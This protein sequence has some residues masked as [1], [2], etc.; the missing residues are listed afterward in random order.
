MATKLTDQIKAIVNRGAQLSEKTIEEQMKWRSTTSIA[1][2]LKITKEEALVFSY[3]YFLTLTKKSFDSQNIRELL[4]NDPFELPRIIT[5]LNDLY[6]S[7]LL[8]RSSDFLSEGYQVPKNI[9]LEI[10][11]NEAPAK[12]NSSKKDIIEICDEI[13]KLIHMRY[14]FTIELDDFYTEMDSIL[15]QH[16]DFAIFTFLK[17]NGIEQIE[18]LI[19]L[20][21]FIA[22]LEGALGANTE[23]II[24]RMYGGTHT[25]FE[26]RTKIQQENTQ[27]QQKGLIEFGGDDIKNPEELIIPEKILIELLGDQY[28]IISSQKKNKFRQNDLIQPEN[29]IERELFYN[30]TEMK[31]IDTLKDLLQPSA[32]AAI[33]ENL[34]Q[35]GYKSGF[36]VMFHGLPGTGKTETVLQLAK[37]TGRTIFKVDI[38][39]IRDKF[40]GETEKNIKEVFDRYRKLCKQSELTPILLFNEADALFNKRISVK[41]SIDQMNN[42]M[43]N[44]LLEELENFDG[45][46]FATT[47]LALNMDSAFER[48]FLYKIKF[49]NPTDEARQ[50]I[51]N[52]HF[53]DL[54]ASKL[55]TIAVEYNLSGGQIE[56][57]VRKAKLQS[58]LYNNPVT[59]DVLKKYCSEETLDNSDELKQIGFKRY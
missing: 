19:F 37:S 29:I 57:V 44:I 25:Q 38:S 13:S 39:T 55:E 24:K 32:F 20:V 41:Q 59:L 3:S 4:T 17:Q 42:A 49:M 36:C 43:Q 33:Q 23:K 21:T 31:N 30:S 52:V 54:E 22:Q 18:W 35:S 50:S 48:R 58:I 15:D 9:L 45:V 2:A 28:D 1:K 16:G 12:K 47:N 53:P 11:R 26:Y 7:K 5:V 8:I 14:E 34:R 10:G 40:V 46:L 51:W 27:L 56:N 6:K